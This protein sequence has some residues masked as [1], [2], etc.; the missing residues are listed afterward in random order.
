MRRTTYLIIL[1]I[2]TMLAKA[3][4]RHPVLLFT[5]P[6]VAEM[7]AGMATAPAFKTSL[8]AT[9]AK[10]EASMKRRI[11]VP[12]PCDGGGGPVHEQHKQNYYTMMNL[13][14]AYQ[15]TKDRRYADFAKKMLLDYADL[16]PTLGWHP[17]TLSSVRGRLFWQTL[18]E[19]VWL[20][21]TSIAYDCIR[22]TLSAKDRKLIEGQLLRP[23]CE[24]IRDGFEGNTANRNTFNKM[25]N[26]GTWADAAVGM[27]GMAMDDETLLQQALYGTDLTGKNGGFVK[28]ISYLFS[29]DGYFTEGAYYQRYALWPF[30][31][32]GLALEH[33][34]PD[35]HIF[36]YRDNTLQ[37]ALDVLVQLSYEGEFFHFNDALEKGLSSQELTYCVCVLYA[38]QPCNK[39]LP[40]IAKR[41]QREIIPCLGGFR[42][43]QAI[44]RGEM[45]P[46]AYRSVILRDGRD[47]N[48][49]AIGIIRSTD[50]KL[51]TAITLKATSHGLA[52]GHYDKLT[53][54]FYDNGREIFFDYGSARFLNVDVKNHGNYTKENNTFVKQTIAH[55]TLVVDGRSHYDS[56]YKL[57]SK[58]HAEMTRHDLGGSK[59]Q[60]LEAVCDNA[61]DGVRMK[62]TVVYLTPEGCRFPI[63]IDV[64]RADSDSPHQYDLP[65]WYRGQMVSTNF[66][67]TR[68]TAQLLPLGDKN[69][70]QHVWDEACGN[71]TAAGF[72]QFTFFNGN[73]FYTI[74]TACNV[75]P[76][77]HLLR[78]G[79]GDPDFNLRAETG[80]LLRL[81]ETKQAVFASVIETHGE[82][83]VVWETAEDIISKCKGVRIVNVSPDSVTLE[84]AFEGWKKQFT[85]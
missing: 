54:A 60:V 83:D 39:M 49:G 85:I 50:S 6:E 78:L 22:E 18:N 64:M 42:I 12:V 55:N 51:N 69:G 41:Y 29:P 31:V 3:E 14:I 26:H 33:A 45:S 74:N 4:E 53:M 35:M 15:F 16:Y 13:G 63:V 5:A 19:S 25:H 30:V 84:V 24:F 36:N 34:K 77:M 82:Y 71:G 79:A 44:E 23:M 52:H 61:Y 57:S 58:H 72:Q 81:S 1:L 32:F 56:D 28:Q 80:Y 59:K 27:A 67:F 46:V 11:S 73:R 75:T 2:V 17:L 38:L 76:E 10:A 20:L 65:Y 43:A 48:E 68:S 37:K 62:R 7:T 21:H 9:I 40:Y 70:Y 8:D 47:G 66:P